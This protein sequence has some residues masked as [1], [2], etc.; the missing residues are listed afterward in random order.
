MVRAKK[1]RLKAG[2]DRLRIVFS[3][4]R[5]RPCDANYT[6]SKYYFQV[7]LE[8]CKLVLKYRLDCDWFERRVQIE[9][10]R[11][12]ANHIAAF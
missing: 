6:F 11:L 9:F 12:P 10:A 2:L 3:A 8:L 1:N 7:A 5:E 4:G